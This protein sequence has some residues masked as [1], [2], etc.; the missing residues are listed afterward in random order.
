MIEIWEPRYRD[1]SVLVAR[2][3]IPAGQDF[4]VLIKKGSRKGL[5]LV[6]NSVVVNSPIEKMKTRT[7]KQIEVRVIPLSKLEVKNA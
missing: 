7:G 3:K 2:F 5:Y 6:K 1:M 4:D